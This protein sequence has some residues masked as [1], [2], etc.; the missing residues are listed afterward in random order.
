[1]KIFYKE[2]CGKHELILLPAPTWRGSVPGI[3]R[4]RWRRET[5]LTHKKGKPSLILG[6][7]GPRA[8]GF[9]S[10]LPSSKGFISQKL[11]IV[12]RLY[13]P[14]TLISVPQQS[15]PPESWQA[16]YQEEREEQTLTAVQPWR[17][18]SQEF[19]AS[20]DKRHH[21]EPWRCND[22]SR[23]AFPALLAVDTFT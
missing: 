8:V 21:P 1:M 19:S 18:S 9:G 20:F 17:S 12:L 5:H 15:T 3:S 6:A 16:H 13:Q 11:T 23:P 22:G 10:L 2:P 7:S 4:I 14:P